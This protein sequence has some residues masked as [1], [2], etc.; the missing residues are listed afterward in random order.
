M[1]LGTSLRFIA[2]TIAW[3]VA[4]LVLGSAAHA[5]TFTVTSM[6]GDDSAGSLSAAMD[7]ANANPS[8]RD[9]INFAAGITD[10]IFLDEDLPVLTGPVEIE[11]PGSDKLA[12][13]GRNP[14]F[15][16]TPHRMFQTDKD[17]T[18][19]G[20]SLDSSA[21]YEAGDNG[22]AIGSTGS[23]LVI[24][25][26][27][28]INSYAASGNG[29]GLSVDGGSLI[30]EDSAILGN[31]AV[32]GGGVWIHGVTSATISN[33]NI[34][35][36]SADYTGNPVPRPYTGGGL[37]VEDSNN[38]EI[39]GSRINGNGSI[40]DG[41]AFS[42][43]NVQNVTIAGTTVADNSTLFIYGD[44][45]Y[46][47]FGTARIV[48]GKTTITDS[49]FNRNFT[50]GSQLAG[51]QVIGPVSISHSTFAGNNSGGPFNGL[52]L[53]T[54]DGIPNTV[55]A[56][57]SDTTITG[58][59]SGP[60][61][62]GLISAVSKL[63]LESS[64]IT[65]NQILFPYSAAASG[66]GLVQMSG[67][68]TL[69]NTIVSGNG[70]SDITAWDTL[71]QPTQPN[72]DFDGYVEGSYNLIGNVAGRPFKDLNPG[73]NITSTDPNLGTLAYDREA[74]TQ[75]MKPA[76][77]SP[78]IDRGLSTLPTDQNGLKRTVDLSNPNAKGGNGTDIGAVEV[79]E[80]TLASYAFNFGRFKPNRK[81]G[82][83]TLQVKVSMPGKIQ[84]LGSRTTRAST[85][86]AAGQGTVVLTIKAKGKAAKQLRKKGKVRLKVKVRF[87]PTDST[88]KTL[89]K[90]VKLVKK[91]PKKRR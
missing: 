73:S 25:D 2:G 75:T 29:G 31:I 83:A 48:A 3:F 35:G 72:T 43:D 89:S 62:A 46:D 10:T 78:A 84:L 30:I 33:T 47:F 91:K 38:L 12:V 39:T 58:N 20:L 53:G 1:G 74:P 69:T 7:L 64:T 11:G 18:M 79:Q 90:T 26:V 52:I 65:G 61:G 76:T 22:G 51:L 66:A 27:N 68:A 49:E 88:P 67:T 34:S 32:G 13:A 80:G 36:N 81:K 44:E 42:I 85:K 86:T 56:T 5:A 21:N 63:I 4:M 55:T 60:L 71:G 14:I 45:N 40:T 50:G 6:A 15:Q 77:G 57:V 17:L 23:N 16:M 28:V 37:L 9:T 54:P 19:T 82:T 24:K 8:D 59:S 41:A 70:L 87:S